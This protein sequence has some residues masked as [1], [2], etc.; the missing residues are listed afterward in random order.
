MYICIVKQNSMSKKGLYHKNKE[1][2]CGETIECP[3]CH[4]TFVKKQWQ[5]AFCCKQCKEKYW[6]QKGDRHK[7]PNYY[8]KYDM[9]HPER[10]ARLDMSRFAA[11]RAEKD[12]AYAVWQYRNDKDFRDYVND[13]CDNWDG[14]WDEHAAYMDLSGMYESY[15]DNCLGR[16]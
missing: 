10:L 15:L 11:T 1:A 5:Q 6:N 7:D 12:H 14:S 2:K 3:V 4:T 8:H 13:S 9:K 16:Y